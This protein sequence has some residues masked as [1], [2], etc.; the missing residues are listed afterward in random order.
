MKPAA[1]VAAMACTVFVAAAITAGARSSV[2]GDRLI[3]AAEQSER[4][5]RSFEAVMQAHAMAIPPDLL[6]RA[7]AV[8]V[9]PRTGKRADSGD[10]SRGVVSRRTNTGWGSPV[11]VRVSAGSVGPQRRAASTDYFLLLMTDESVEELLNDRIGSGNQAAVAAGPVVGRNAG[12]EGDAS[13]RTAI[14]SYSS[15]RGLFAGVDVRG[16][17]IEPDDDLNLA[18]YNQT[19]HD[20][21][22]GRAA[23]SENGSAFVRSFPETVDRYTIASGDVTARTAV[24]H[25][26][27]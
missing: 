25:T 27:A 4:A 24:L 9:F 14:L 12:A 2:K 15:R 16:I 18:V 5:A 20:L 22:G 17:V 26:V 7:K 19:A 3:A 8:V 11:F 6:G 10:G 23:G 13:S 21:L 1:G